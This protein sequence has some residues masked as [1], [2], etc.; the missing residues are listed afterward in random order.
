MRTEHPL[1]PLC[2]PPPLDHVRSQMPSL[3]F[4]A[5]V[6]KIERVF[7]SL[8]TVHVAPGDVNSLGQIQSSPLS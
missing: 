7:L 8:G 5:K 1:T 6:L 3:F 2:N 4:R